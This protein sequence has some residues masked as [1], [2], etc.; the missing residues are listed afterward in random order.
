MRIMT[1]FDW[2][3]LLLEFAEGLAWPVVAVI[4]IFALREQ[5]G[6]LLGRVEEVILTR[7]KDKAVLK[8]Q[9]EKVKL[10]PIDAEVR[11]VQNDD[12]TL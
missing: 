2:V 11:E 6:A 7:G 8:L 5:L 4:A 12:K 1:S 10:P 9:R 3:K